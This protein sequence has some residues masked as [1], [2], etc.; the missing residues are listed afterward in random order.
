VRNEGYG[1]RPTKAGK[2]QKMT[3]D[4]LAAEAPEI[5]LEEYDVNI[6]KSP[7]AQGDTWEIALNHK[8]THKRRCF[9]WV[10]QFASASIQE[11]AC[12]ETT[13]PDG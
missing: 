2:P 3:R 12:P 5:R 9:H 1:A 8:F 11:I 4:Y 6:Q 10:G 7:A 13:E